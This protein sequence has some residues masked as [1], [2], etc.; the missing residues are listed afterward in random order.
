MH[1][2]HLAR[3]F[4]VGTQRARAFRQTR[5]GSLGLLVFALGLQLLI[6]PRANAISVGQIDRFQTGT[7]ENWVEG[8]GFGVP[9]V[10][11]AAVA[12]AGPNGAGDFALLVTAT[13][14]VIGAGGKLVINNI[15][16]RWAGSY[17]AAGVGWIVVDVRNPNTVPLRIRIGVDGP[18]AG[19]TG[20][21]WIT[22]QQSIPPQSG[23]QTFYFPI[24]A[25]SLLPGDLGATNVATTLANVAVLRVMHGTQNTWQGEPILGQMFVDNIEALP[26][27]AFASG[28]VAGII[29]LVAI[30]RIP[31]R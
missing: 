4:A 14:A 28:L 16:P 8:L 19:A 13:G 22:P 20:G 6:G 23:W 2:I 24:N 25:Q 31:R 15:Q 17:T 27:P 1:P 7:T 12:S 11:P 21:K 29:A 3:S 10:P 26:E 30:G 18:A 5:P 9:P